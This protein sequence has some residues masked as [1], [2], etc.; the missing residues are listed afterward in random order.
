MGRY[1]HHWFWKNSIDQSKGALWAYLHSDHVKNFGIGT[2][3]YSALGPAPENGGWFTASKNSRSKGK[4]WIFT[5]EDGS[6]F[7]CRTHS[8]ASFVAVKA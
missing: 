7:S 2:A 6:K 8:G 5:M 3:T 4:K 1:I